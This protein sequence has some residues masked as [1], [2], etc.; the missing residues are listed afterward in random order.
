M[1]LGKLPEIVAVFPHS[2]ISEIKNNTGFE[3]SNSN[4]KNLE[5]VSRKDRS[6]LEK[7]DKNSI[8]YRIA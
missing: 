2:S 1:K 5:E 6:T 4:A 3:L 7:I 8:R